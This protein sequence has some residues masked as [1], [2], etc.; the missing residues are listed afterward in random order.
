MTL[1]Q[2][3]AQGEKTA[4]PV[5]VKAAIKKMDRPPFL[6][7]VLL[8]SKTFEKAL[9]NTGCLCYSAFNGALVCR[10]KLPRIPIKERALQLAEGDQEEKKI[11]SITYVDLDVDRYKE[12]IFRYIIEKLAYPMILGDPWLHY[13]KAVYRAG[14]WTLQIGSKK[15]GIVV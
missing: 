3:R 12:R 6:I 15:Y 4:S 5:E 13:N 2:S 10:L 8:N 14:P 7:D 9:I 1:E 11:R